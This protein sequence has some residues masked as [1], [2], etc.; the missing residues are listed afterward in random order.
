MELLEFA[1][2]LR[3]YCN[4]RINRCGC[5]RLHGFHFRHFIVAVSFICS[6]VLL[7]HLY[8]MHSNT[9][10]NITTKH[11]TQQTNNSQTNQP[12]TQ[13]KQNDTPILYYLYAFTKPQ[14]GTH[15]TIQHNTYAIQIQ[16]EL[17]RYTGIESTA[18]P[19]AAM[20][21]GITYFAPSGVRVAA[22]G[23]AIGMGA[24]GATYA[25]YAAMGRPVGSA[26]FLWF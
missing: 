25:G 20:L 9:K 2:I 4:L 13:W 10:R 1:T 11:H 7:T 17:D 5:L 18:P 19:L 16:L 12:Q 24:V 3:Y 14:I 22:L 6:F 26:T 23:G 15:I 8:S 21:T